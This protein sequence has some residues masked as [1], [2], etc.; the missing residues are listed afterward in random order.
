MTEKLFD[1]MIAGCVPVYWGATDIEDH[2]DPRC[3]VDARRFNGPLEI[4]RHLEDMNE[5]TW[6]SHRVMAREWMNSAKADPYRIETFVGKIL[7]TIL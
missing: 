4:L 7:G 3:Y 5:T 2:V 6:R 1:A